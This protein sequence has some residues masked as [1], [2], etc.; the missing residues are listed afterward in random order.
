MENI[1]LQSNIRKGNYCLDKVI[2]AYLKRLNRI[3][4][5]IWYTSKGSGMFSQHVINGTTASDK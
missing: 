3:L 5:S 4:Q 1:L 2:K